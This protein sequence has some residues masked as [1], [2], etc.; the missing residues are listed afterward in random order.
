V[1]TTRPT[2]FWWSVVHPPG[3]QLECLCRPRSPPPCWRCEPALEGMPRDPLFS[4]NP[5]LLAFGR[6]PYIFALGRKHA[7][8]G[9]CC[10][11]D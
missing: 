2:V 10:S 4:S 6:R 1:R 11:F 7:L 3:R 9:S 5:I 8:N